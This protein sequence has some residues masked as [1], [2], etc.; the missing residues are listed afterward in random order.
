MRMIYAS[1]PN[2]AGAGWLWSAMLRLSVLI[3]AALALLAVTLVGL[4]VVLPLMIAG[5]IALS[6]FLRRRLRRAQRRPMDGVI[7]ADYTVIEHR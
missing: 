5:S 7:D 4:F 2:R 3:T 1:Q 6:F